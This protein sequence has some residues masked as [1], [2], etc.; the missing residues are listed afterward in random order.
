MRR[1]MSTTSRSTRAGASCHG[2]CAIS[3][4]TR[5]PRRRANRA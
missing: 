1:V 3:P 4:H 2:A 5:R